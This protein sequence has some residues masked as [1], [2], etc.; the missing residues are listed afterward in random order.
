MNE[1]KKM[2]REVVT[3]SGTGL[4][5]MSV[6]TI[7][8]AVLANYGFQGRDHHIVLFAFIIAVLIYASQA[9][10]IY[11]NANLF[12]PASEEEKLEKKEKGK[13]FGIIFAL[14]GVFIPVAINVVTWLGHPE[15]GLPAMAL[16][17]GLHF[18]PLAWVFERKIDYLLGSWATIVALTTAYYAYQHLWND[19]TIAAVI[20][21][22]MALTTSGYAIYMATYGRSLISAVKQP[23]FA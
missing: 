18:F 20:G 19:Y 2:A 10:F 15:L 6:F 17:V 16:V 1:I 21:T 5:L 11:R 22:G 8:W 7:A 14:E 12:E 3:G 9:V 4:V 13:W 23:K